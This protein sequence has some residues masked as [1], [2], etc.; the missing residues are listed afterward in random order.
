M[1][2][3]PFSRTPV[4]HIVSSSSARGLPDGGQSEVAEDY[5]RSITKEW[6]EPTNEFV[7]RATEELITFIKKQIWA[8]CEHLSYGELYS[9]LLCGH[10]SI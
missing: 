3:I 4:D 7:K 2:A 1:V 9:H 10:T 5:I 8:Q 6:A